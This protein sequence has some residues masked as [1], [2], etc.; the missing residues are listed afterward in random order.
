MRSELELIGSE[1]ESSSG[2]CSTLPSKSQHI[3]GLLTDI[4]RVLH[5]Y[6]NVREK[7]L[8]AVLSNAQ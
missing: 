4:V 2:K 5:G 3:V 8:M 6:L 1:S 7:V